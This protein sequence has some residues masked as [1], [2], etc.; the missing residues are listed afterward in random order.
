MSP[1][2]GGS[3]DRAAEEARGYNGANM[4]RVDDTIVREYFEENR[5]LV[6]QVRP[7]ATSSR[8]QPDD[9][10]SHFLVSNPAYRTDG[11][12][13]GFFLFPSELPFIKHAW[14]TVRSAGS[15]RFS[16]G[17]LKGGA[18]L[19]RFLEQNVAKPREQARPEVEG[20]EEM[21]NLLRIL[22]LPGLPT[23]EPYRGQVTELLR[24]RGVDGIISFRSMLAEIIAR[25]ETGRSYPESDILEAL[26]VLKQYDLIG[27]SQLELFGK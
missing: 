10:E 8:K 24:S 27:D 17:I 16:P 26:R 15:P 20:L 1:I 4:G 14:V 25:V 22:V 18:R 3:S 21:E 9:A 19:L 11:R 13:P 2:F 7:A 12:K 23:V 5:F 6:R